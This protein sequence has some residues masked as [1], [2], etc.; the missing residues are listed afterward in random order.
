M[1]K[2]AIVNGK[3]LTITNGTVEFGTV[4]LSDG[5]ILAAG[6]GL[7]PPSDAFVI[8]ATGKFVMPGMIDAHTHLGVWEDGVGWEGR[9]I[10]EA[11]SPATPHLR[12]VDAINPDDIAFADALS[13]GVTSVLVSP[14]SSNVIGGQS[15]VVKTFGKVIDEM[16]VREPA[17]LKVA[18]GGNP[19]GT[20]GSQRKMPSTRMGIAAVLREWLVRGSEYR[21]KKEAAAKNQ[22]S[23]GKK[24]SEPPDR[25][26][27]LEMLGRVLDG[28]IPLRIHVARADDIM[29]ALRISVEF[30]VRVVLEHVTEGHLVLDELLD[31][32]IPVVIG[33][34]LVSKGVETRNLSFETPGTLAQAG[35]K[36]ALMTDHPVVPVKYLPLHA[37]L[38]V[39]EGMGMEDALRAITINAAAVLGI[40]DRVGSIETG[41]DADIVILSGHPFSLMSRVEKVLVGGEVVYELIE[42]G[43]YR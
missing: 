3:I 22:N 19:K 5:K 42:G 9:D 16:I 39:R 26:L 34:M 13:A 14:G 35:V 20:Y 40:D 10:N 8:D 29:T 27:G 23:E 4:L 36:V 25:D 11:T 1:G 32:D 30:G 31:A 15:V 41:K 17:G 24:K 6:N 33:P 7:L 21:R 12:A 28:D 38:C 18:L 43:E 37:G 2:I